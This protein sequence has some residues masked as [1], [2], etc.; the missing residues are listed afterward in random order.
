MNITKEVQQ[1]FNAFMANN[2]EANFEVF[3][4]MLHLYNSSAKVHM[5]LTFFQHFCN[6][7]L[8]EALEG[9]FN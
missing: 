3:M 4:E 1:A 8:C 2:S 6:A 9:R 5:C 7:D